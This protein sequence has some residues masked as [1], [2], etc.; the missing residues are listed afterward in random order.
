[1]SDSNDTSAIDNKKNQHS[2]TDSAE[3]YLPK[4]TGFLYS[5]VLIFIIILTLEILKR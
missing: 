1:M 5:V 3:S 4:V 2:S